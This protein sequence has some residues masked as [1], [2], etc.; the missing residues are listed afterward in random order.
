VIEK[1]VELT[2]ETK[3]VLVV[4]GARGRDRPSCEQCGRADMVTPEEIAAVSGLSTRTIYRRLEAGQ[5]H[6]R[7]TPNGLLFIC[8]N[9]IEFSD[10]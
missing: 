3:Q 9:S 2:L 7:E 6:F 10:S 1:R 8:F 4:R 5:L